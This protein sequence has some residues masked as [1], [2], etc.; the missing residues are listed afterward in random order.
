MLSG[1]DMTREELAEMLSMLQGSKNSKGKGKGASR[2][3]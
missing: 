3:E 2:E 1:E